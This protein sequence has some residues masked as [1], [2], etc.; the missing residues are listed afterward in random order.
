MSCRELSTGILKL[1]GFAG[2]H[3]SQSSSKGWIHSY[4]IVNINQPQPHTISDNK[5]NKVIEAIKLKGKY[6]IYSIRDI[7]TMYINFAE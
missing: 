1:T 6:S 3:S 4:N 5:L 2:I 7:F